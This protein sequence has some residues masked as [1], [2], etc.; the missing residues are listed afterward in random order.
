MKP[1]IS[2]VVHLDT[3]AIIAV[4]RVVESAARPIRRQLVC[5]MAH[6][7]DIG[8]IQSGLLAIGIRQPT[9]KMVEAAILHHHHDDV[10][11]LGR[12]RAQNLRA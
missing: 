6:A 1:S 11:D 2:P 8:V 9:Q 5:R 4:V 7:V 12:S 10:F 3:P